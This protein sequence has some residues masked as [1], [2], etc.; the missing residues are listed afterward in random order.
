MPKQRRTF[1]KGKNCKKHTLHKV[2]QYKK[3]RESSSAQGA[4]AALSGDGT[5]SALLICYRGP[6]WLRCRDSDSGARGPGFEPYDR[7]VIEQD[8]LRFPKY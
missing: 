7:R 2:T 6:R 3:G 5:Y 4:Y 1:C 8:T